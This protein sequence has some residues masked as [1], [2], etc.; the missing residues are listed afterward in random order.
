[1][2][3][4]KRIPIIL[5]IYF[6]PKKVQTLD[7]ITL[8]VDIQLSSQQVDLPLVTPEAILCGEAA[9]AEVAFV[10]ADGQV[11]GQ[12]VALGRRLPGR[13]VGA[14]PALGARNQ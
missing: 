4:K 9:S 2:L 7:K 1:M 11:L 5:N 6:N 10:A 8:L 12:H 13:A 3:T 14:L